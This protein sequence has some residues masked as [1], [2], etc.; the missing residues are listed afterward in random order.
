MKDN[1][2][3]N[4]TIT[5]V[6]DNAVAVNL[7]NQTPNFKLMPFKLMPLPQINI[8]NNNNVN[9]GL[10]NNGLGAADRVN[11]QLVPFT[12]QHF[13][14]NNN[15]CIGT[16]TFNSNDPNDIIESRGLPSTL[17]NN[18]YNNG[19]TAN[20]FAI[21]NNEFV[22]RIST[23]NFYKP[24]CEKYLKLL[25]KE[26]LRLISSADGEY[27]ESTE[28]KINPNLYKH[29]FTN[30]E[31]KEEFTRNLLLHL[32]LRKKEYREDIIK[33]YDHLKNLSERF[34]KMRPEIKRLIDKMQKNIKSIDQIKFE[35]FTK[36][37]SELFQVIE[38]Q[39]P[40]ELVKA[41]KIFNKNKG[42]KVKVCVIDD[43]E[44][45]E[46][47]ESSTFYND[48]LND[49]IS[50]SSLDKK[51]E[52]Y[53]HATEVCGVM[54][55]IVDKDIEFNIYNIFDIFYHH[56]F[57][58][59]ISFEDSKVI[60]MS[61]KFNSVF[62]KKYG[63][64]EMLFQAHSKKCIFVI[65]LGNNGTKEN[66]P[67]LDLISK[68]EDLKQ[69]VIFVVS[70]MSDGKTI[71]PF[72][73]IP[74]ENKDLQKMTVCA[75]GSNIKTYTTIVDEEKWKEISPKKEFND[76][77]YDECSGT[78]FA[79]PFVTTLVGII[80]RDFPELT[81]AEIVQIVKDGCSPPPTEEEHLFGN[82]LINFEASYE[83]AENLYKERFSEV[84]VIGTNIEDID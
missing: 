1:N 26:I 55:Q 65:S 9:L 82:G 54:Q 47:L 48:K 6:P 3:N 41:N 10:V 25:P 84:S 64:E 39:D 23:N 50:K 5:N 43:F 73:N 62:D 13:I 19:N 4:F 72:S 8:D 35:F 53:P 52:A 66:T 83:I 81:L 42:N 46:K 11:D 17:T 44:K 61:F 78:S 58:N 77:G 30:E 51:L 37:Y 12:S 68:N 75:P 28:K 40:F 31:E 69:S 57:L 60:N 74:G 2:N 56:C 15:N 59:N 33:S 36:S 16:I 49:K 14:E 21:T 20:S 32:Q 71:S 18:I 22:S 45:N 34:E 7:N 80:A 24:K 38:T 79:A 27:Q 63:Q 67:C 76:T 70:V 29:F